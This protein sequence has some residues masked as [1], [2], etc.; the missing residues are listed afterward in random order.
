MDK[1]ELDNWKKVKEAL[2]KANKTDCYYYKRAIE[3]VK[4]KP[5]PLDN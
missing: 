3:I 1:Q 5:D 2:E 4:G